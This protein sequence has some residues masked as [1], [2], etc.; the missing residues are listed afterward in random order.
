MI[1]TW[2]FNLIIY[3]IFMII[4]TQFYKI[5]AV[6]GK[7]DGALTILIQVLSGILGLIWIPFFKIQFPSNI[8][9]WGFLLISIVFYAIA[10]RL[11][12]TARRGLGA[13]EFSILGQLVNVFT[14]IFGVIFFKEEVLLKKVIGTVLIIAGNI[15]VL[16]EKGKLQ[17][18]KYTIFSISR[19]QYL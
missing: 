19:R 17:W 6:N 10:D 3:I 16:F 15:F 2:E 14:I 13:S 1:E 11:N 12:T 4:F 9:T 18:N 5:A 8:I 7:N